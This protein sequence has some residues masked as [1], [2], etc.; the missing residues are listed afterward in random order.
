MKKLMIA[1]ALATMPL[2]ASCESVNLSPGVTQEV[3]QELNATMATAERVYAL[4]RRI[5]ELGVDAGVIRGATATRLAALDNDLYAA[6]LRARSAYR[7]GNLALL[8]VEK[9]NL[10]SLADQVNVLARGN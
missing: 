10:E 6:L 4:S 9:G 5:G 1:V 2:T 3:R 7:A 8:T